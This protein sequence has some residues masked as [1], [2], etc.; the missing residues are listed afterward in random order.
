MKTLLLITLVALMA[1]CHSD[2]TDSS[3]TIIHAKK[4]AENSF[5]TA[6]T[7]VQVL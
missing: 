7:W 3:D 4:L 1:A 6:G 2:N 5:A